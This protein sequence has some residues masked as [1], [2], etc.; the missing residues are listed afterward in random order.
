MFCFLLEEILYLSLQTVVKITCR[1]I[2]HVTAGL[3]DMWHTAY[4]HTHHI[5]QLTGN[6]MSA[7]FFRLSVSGAFLSYKFHECYL[8]VKIVHP[9][10]HNSNI[11][12]ITSLPCTCV[13]H[14]IHCLYWD[15]YLC[16][17]MHVCMYLCAHECVCVCGC[18]WLCVVV[19][20]SMCPETLVITYAK[21]KVAFCTVCS[22]LSLHRSIP[23]AITACPIWLAS[24]FILAPASLSDP[25]VTPIWVRVIPVCVWLG[26][27]EAIGESEEGREKE[28]ERLL[29]QAHSFHEEQHL[30]CPSSLSHRQGSPTPLSQYLL[31]S[32]WGWGGPPSHWAHFAEHQLHHQDQLASWTWGQNDS[33]LL[34][35]CWEEAGGC[36][37]NESPSVD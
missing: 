25:C 24:L 28:I 37:Q 6:P 5:R 26:V 13:F 11:V 7:S 32:A 10:T 1:T 19:Y 21:Y 12:F 35:H 33:L 3:P 31:P 17:C 9:T 36:C 18:V 14:K 8:L 27:N 30:V 16:V 2:L 20:A 23:V 29:F 22:N 15:M 34:G 4:T